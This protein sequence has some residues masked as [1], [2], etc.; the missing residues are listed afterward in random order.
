MRVSK[1]RYKLINPRYFSGV[2]SNSD[3]L[4]T[5]VSDYIYE[6]YDLDRVEKSIYREMVPLG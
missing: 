2:Y 3:E 1:D 5:E 6:A 4:W